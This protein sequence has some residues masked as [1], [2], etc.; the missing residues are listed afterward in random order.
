MKVAELEGAALDYW[1]AQAL[2][3]ECLEAAA[4]YREVWVNDGICWLTRACTRLFN[5]STD[6]ALGGPILAQAGITASPVLSDKSRWSAEGFTHGSFY[7]EG[8]TLLQ[9]AMRCFVASK[10][11]EDVD[12]GS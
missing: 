11:G 7:Q 4:Y 2:R 1:V 10:F 5:P 3:R 9:A 8:A 12:A 6:W